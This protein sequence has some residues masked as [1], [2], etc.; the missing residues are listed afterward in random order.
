MDNSSSAVTS[1]RRIVRA[2]SRPNLSFSYPIKK[3]RGTLPLSMT[4]VLLPTIVSANLPSQRPSPKFAEVEQVGAQG[5][6][7]QV[8]LKTQSVCDF[9]NSPLV[10]DQIAGRRNYY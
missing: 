5:S 2:Y 3:I 4:V 10:S 9:L 8:E 1:G 6:F 7:L